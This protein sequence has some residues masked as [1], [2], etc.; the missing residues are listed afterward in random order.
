[1][2]YYSKNLGG[3]APMCDSM[4]LLKLERRRLSGRALDVSYGQSR[5]GKGSLMRRT[6]LIEEIELVFAMQLSISLASMVYASYFYFLD[7]L[8]VTSRI[9]VL[10]TTQSRVTAS[11]QS[12]GTWRRPRV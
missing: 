10:I 3:W 1:M 8:M 11:G 9:T 2:K 7:N 5:K 6:Y 12:F 4:P